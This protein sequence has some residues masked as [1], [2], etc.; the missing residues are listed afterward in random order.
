[1]ALCDVQEIMFLKKIIYIKK[2]FL[3]VSKQDFNLKVKHGNCNSL[4][5]TIAKEKKKKKKGKVMQILQKKIIIMKKKAK[6]LIH[7]LYI[8]FSFF[9][10]S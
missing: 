8:F 10:N 5:F 2:R 4:V 3:N 1:M 9:K 6:S 7:F